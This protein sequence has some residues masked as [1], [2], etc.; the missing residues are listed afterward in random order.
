MDRSGFE[1][2]ASCLRSPKALPRVSR[3]KSELKKW[4]IQKGFSESYK[5][6]ITTYLKPLENRDV[7]SV[8]ELREIIASSSS[9]M[10]LTVTRAYI[11]FLLENEIIT[12]DTAIYFRKALPSRKTNV[13]GYVPADQ[14]VRNA[15][16]K[17]KKE[18][19]RILFEILAFS[20][21]RITELVKMLKEFDPTRSITD[22]QISK[23]PLNYS[24][25]NKRSQYVYM[26]S[27][28]ATR[29]HRLYINKDTVSRDLRKYGVAPKYLRKWF[30]NFLI[31]NNVPESVA[32]FIE[33]RAPES[34]GSMHYLAKVKQADYWYNA[35]L[36][37]LDRSLE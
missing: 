6:E 32:D 28:L 3:Y 16:Q 22:K 8:A 1:P 15:Y 9:N 18:K 29:L 21:I 5:S 24:R 20:G 14:D 10:I 30:Y 26:P 19:D 12:D 11:N 13:D 31:M 4:M 35:I 34:V 37:E 7:S 23:Y 33:G 27:E 2:E 25:G 17:I 36:K